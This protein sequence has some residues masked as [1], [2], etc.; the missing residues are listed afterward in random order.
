LFVIASG[1]VV[2]GICLAA[3]T[4]S[5]ELTET[6]LQKSIAVS[7][8][9]KITSFLIV[10]FM[11]VNELGEH[12]RT[13][14]LRGRILVYD[15]NA[16][17]IR[18]LMLPVVRQF[19]PSLYMGFP[20][21]YFV[22]YNNI[23]SLNGTYVLTETLYVGAPNRTRYYTD[24]LGAPILNVPG[25][26]TVYNSTLRPWYQQ[27]V[28]AKAPIFS[29]IYSF[30]NIRVRGKDGPLFVRFSHIC[31][32]SGSRRLCPSLSICSRRRFI[33]WASRWTCAPRGPFRR[34]ATFAA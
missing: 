23:G 18:N 20:S 28:A 24:P 6:S 17:F 34:I 8:V 3:G 14:S 31:S 13:Q 12:I 22:G 11:G 30:A 2:F 33:R 15:T 5:V 10:S 4:A 21:G 26:T 29:T 7:I 27:C 1:L 19:V 9:N 16:T 32:L 25:S